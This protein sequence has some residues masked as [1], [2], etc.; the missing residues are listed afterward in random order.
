MLIADPILADDRIDKL[1]AS[2]RKSATEIAVWMRDCPNW[3]SDTAEPNREK[4]RMLMLLPVCA[5]WSTEMALPARRKER[6]LMLEA[7]NT[8][9]TTLMCSTLPTT[10]QPAALIEEPKRTKDRTLMEDPV[11]L[12]P[13]TDNELPRRANARS[14]SVEP[15]PM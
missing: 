1:L 6:M 9:P 12:G 13:L 7:I 2:N 14:D 11:S 15:A 5:C 10:P 4:E 8:C 3:Y